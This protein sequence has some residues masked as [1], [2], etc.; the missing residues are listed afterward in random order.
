MHGPTRHSLLGIFLALTLLAGGMPTIAPAVCD[1]GCADSCGDGCLDCACCAPTR[2][3]AL[4]GVP[5]G[6]TLETAARHEAEPTPRTAHADPRDI[7]H[8]PRLAV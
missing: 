2:A 6:P 7:F 8:V 5:T 3:P 4:L 1:D